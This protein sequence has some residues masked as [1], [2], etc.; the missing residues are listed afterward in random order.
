[1]SGRGDRDNREGM[2]GEEGSDGREG[3]GWRAGREAQSQ[4]IQHTGVKGPPVHQESF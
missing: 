4:K 1:L 2:G 3:E